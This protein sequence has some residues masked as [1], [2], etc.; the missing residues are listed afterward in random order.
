MLLI[1]RLTQ[2][3]LFEVFMLGIKNVVDRFVEEKPVKR[4]GET[5]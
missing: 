2:S 3:Q 5:R 1:L 4:G